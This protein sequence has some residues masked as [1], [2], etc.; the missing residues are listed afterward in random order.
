MRI[1]YKE[2]YI[3]TNGFSVGVYYP[4]TEFEKDKFY[5]HYL[6]EDKNNPVSINT[7]KVKELAF[8]VGMVLNSTPKKMKLTMVDLKE[9]FTNF[10]E[11][12]GGNIKQ[13]L[14]YLQA[15]DRDN[16]LNELGI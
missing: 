12:G 4:K 8:K 1:K 3:E 11:L 15:C 5:F 10:D 16:K 7:S 6:T 2:T 13:F 9:K 14:S